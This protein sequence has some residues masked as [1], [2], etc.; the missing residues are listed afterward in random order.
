MI[1]LYTG[2]KYLL[3]GREQVTIVKSFNKLSTRNVVETSDRSVILVETQRLKPTKERK[4]MISQA[5]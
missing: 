4:E 2:S 3:D 1:N 5:V